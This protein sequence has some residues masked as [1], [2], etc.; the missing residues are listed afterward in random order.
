MQRQ[1]D[2]HAYVV[3]GYIAVIA[4]AGDGGFAHVPELMQSV[5]AVVNGDHGVTC[6]IIDATAVNGV[7]PTP[8]ALQLAG[9]R[10]R[11]MK[12]I[13]VAAAIGNDGRTLEV[14]GVTIT[15]TTRAALDACGH[16]AVPIVGN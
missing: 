1:A 10:P 7:D 3:G 5:T 8:L 2:I 4:V 6:V 13:I 9:Y 15:A 11:H 14:D 12:L 16:K